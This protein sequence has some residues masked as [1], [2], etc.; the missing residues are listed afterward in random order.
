MT[1]QTQEQTLSVNKPPSERGVHQA[2][3]PFSHP[4][5]PKVQHETQWNLYVTAS[6][7]SEHLQYNVMRFWLHDLSGVSE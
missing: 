5:R 6:L 3:N 7:L 4:V 2:H 1:S